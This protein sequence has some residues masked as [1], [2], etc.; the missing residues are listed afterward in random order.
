[1]KATLAL[2]GMVDLWIQRHDNGLIYR[3][4]SHPL[5]IPNRIL[6]GGLE[7]PKT[8]LFP[9]CFSVFS[10]GTDNTPTVD[11]MTHLAAYLAHSSSGSAGGIS[12]DTA[13]GTVEM[14]KTVA[15]FSNTSGEAV[16]I[17]ELGFGP[18]NSADAALFSRVAL[19]TPVSVPD[20]STLI[21]QYTFRLAVPYAAGAEAVSL[22][23]TGAPQA[24]TIQIIKGNNGGADN[25]KLLRCFAGLSS[26][27]GYNANPE[28]ST[29]ADVGCTS[30][31][32]EPSYAAEGFL[33]RTSNP[34]VILFGH[35]D[36]YYSTLDNKH[37]VSVD[38]STSRQTT[39]RWS[40]AHTV[41]PGDTT[42]G[43]FSFGDC[44][45][46]NSSYTRGSGIHWRADA[47]ITK[48]TTSTWHFDFTLAWARGT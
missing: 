9:A 1:M 11:T 5:T 37:A 43:G 4:A 47:P 36:A 8:H 40:F 22:T 42:I 7:M 28:T 38:T 14:T 18:T 17:G 29:N 32:L 41:L 27:G 2:T 23:V 45:G 3:P 46:E 20:G 35:A 24:G 15:V 19:P 34:N 6:D 39:R 48:N 10:V 12:Q 26:V 31:C 13:A 44:E 30:F 25:N 33:W 16:N 21:V